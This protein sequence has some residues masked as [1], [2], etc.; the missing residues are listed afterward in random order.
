[1]TSEPEHGGL[2]QYAVA[3]TPCWC[4][5]V[6]GVRG[7]IHTFQRYP[8]LRLTNQK[9][10]KCPKWFS[11]S[12]E[13]IDV[14]CPGFPTTTG[15]ATGERHQLISRRRPEPNILTHS[16]SSA[17][18]AQPIP[19]QIDRLEVSW[20]DHSLYLFRLYHYRLGNKLLF[21][22][23]QDGHGGSHRGHRYQVPG[24]L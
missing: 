16:S 20:S 22:R 8:N 5:P 6:A 17:V 9:S 3:R 4:E 15:T 24:M 21:L 14:P 7:E 1:M 19:T 18:P 10:S 12:R 11:S 2:R 13:C 23:G